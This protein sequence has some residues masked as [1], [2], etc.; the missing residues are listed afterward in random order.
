MIFEL[1]RQEAVKLFSQRFIYV[2]IA[3]VLLAQAGRMIVMSLSPAETSLDVVTGPQLWAEGAG[4]GLRLAVYVVMI[5]G[6]MGFSQ[7]YSLGTVKTML[8]L[9]ILRWEWALAKIGFLS[10]LAIGLVLAIV[11]LGL[12]ITAAT[13]GMGDVVREGLVL[14]SARSVWMNILG[15]T[16]LTMVFM[17]PVC[18]L[19]LLVGL[20]FTSSGAAVG[21]SL[22]LAIVLEVAVGLS[23]WQKYVFLHYLHRPFHMVLR[24]GK[25]MPFQWEALLSWGLGATLIS[26]AGFTLW[27][28]WRFNRMDITT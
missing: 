26:F 15:A 14:Y 13:T 6:A 17:L 22:L 12:V 27:L 25:G 5:V 24:M 23:G 9:P 20:Y 8:I 19:A 11:L 7:E 1:C 4:L 3:L 18:A 28:V 16:A 21:V 2:I 10:A